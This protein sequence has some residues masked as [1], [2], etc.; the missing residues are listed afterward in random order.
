MATAQYMRERME[1]MQAMK[2]S[3]SHLAKGECDFSPPLE[4]VGIYVAHTTVSRMVARGE[5]TE[6]AGAYLNAALGAHSFAVCH[7]CTHES[8]SQHNP[9]HESFEN[10]VFRLSSFLIFFDDGYRE[11]HRAHHARCNEPDDPDLLMSHTSLP[12]LGNLISTMSQHGYYLGIGAPIGVRTV[13]ALH[14]LG[15]TPLLR[16]TWLQKWSPLINWDN[17]AGKMAAFTAQEVLEQHEEYKDLHRTLQATWRGATG[18]TYLILALFFG[19]YPHR[20]GA[21]MVNEVDSFY[22][23]TYRGQGQVDLWMMG[24]G[25][26][27]LHHAKSDVSSSRLPAVCRE[28]EERRPE[29]KVVA[30]GN[31]D[32]RTLEREHVLPPKRTE[33]SP[34]AVEFPSDRTALVMESKELLAHDP[35]QAVSGFAEAALK[36]A[37]HCCCNADRELL[38][39]IHKEMRFGRPKGDNHPLPVEMW[40]KTVFAD[41]TA[42][43]L[44]AEGD[45]ILAEVANTA[46]GVGARVAPMADDNELKTRYLDFFTALADE[47][48]A[49]EQQALFLERLAASLPAPTADS[50][51]AADALRQALEAPVPSDFMRKKMPK[52]HPAKTRQ[53]VA[54]LLSGIRSRL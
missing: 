34:S 15:L 12:V 38:R 25:P 29:L 43:Y 10:V 39:E 42:A 40:H 7:H 6:T 22:D 46:R 45:R 33:T 48:V 30:R 1:L 26:H 24:E 54:N 35:Q 28:I 50:A 20:N 8:I 11:A 4:L 49:P 31:E 32:L 23:G 9:E 19:R 5:L 44:Q 37:L 3:P 47:M 21:R 13:T 16:S 14:H 36:S 52:T 27:D 17:V 53:K 51:S 2:E 18:V 41:E